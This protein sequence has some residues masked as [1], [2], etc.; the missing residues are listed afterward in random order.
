[1]ERDSPGG[2]P[3]SAARRRSEREVVMDSQRLVR[4]HL[5]GQRCRSA[6]SNQQ[7]EFDSETLWISSL[8]W[9][10]PLRC[11]PTHRL[12]QAR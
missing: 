11:D 1:M 10:R 8:L 3:A 2:A 6:S 9:L 7:V 4:R 5:L 12:K